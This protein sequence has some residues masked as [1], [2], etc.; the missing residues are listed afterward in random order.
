MSTPIIPREI[1]ER[2]ILI[3]SES[4]E[5]AE[6]DAG[7]DAGEW[8]GPSHARKAD[9]KIAVLAEANGYTFDDLLGAIN[10][11]THINEGE[12]AA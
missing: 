8:S 7:F 3:Y 12:V 1:V 4:E 6:A 5:S 11:L 2:A 10:D 9:E